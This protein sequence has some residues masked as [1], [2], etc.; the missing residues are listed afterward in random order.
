MLCTHPL[1]REMSYF[2]APC[3]G[4][5]CC[6]DR[7]THPVLASCALVPNGAALSSCWGGD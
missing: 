5:D 1:L 4:T 7:L 2:V 3:D 6:A